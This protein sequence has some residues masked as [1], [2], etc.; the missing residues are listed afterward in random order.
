MRLARSFHIFLLICVTGCF[1]DRQSGDSSK[2]AVPRLNVHKV[3]R[4]QNGSIQIK[5]PKGWKEDKE[6]H[7]EAELQASN[8][9][10]EKYVIDLTDNKEDFEKMSLAEHSEITRGSILEVLT[11]PQVT[12]PVELTINGS[13]AIQ[14]EIRGGTEN[15]NVVYLHTTVETPSMFYQV[16]AWTLKSRFEKNKSELQEVTNSFQESAGPSTK[17]KV[18]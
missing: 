11:S 7:D 1:S 12:G 15:I 5:L 10:G 13:P 8:R 18:P 14:Y 17:E 16:L 9:A 2:K 3:L 6:L 4:S